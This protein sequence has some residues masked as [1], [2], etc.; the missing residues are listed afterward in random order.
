MRFSHLEGSDNCDVLHQFSYQC[1]L[2]TIVVST[3]AFS[4]VNTLQGLFTLG[5]MSV[6]ARGLL[7]PLLFVPMIEIQS[8][9]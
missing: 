4:F 1:N 2:I 7:Y 3:N 8:N 5:S 9:M 6:R